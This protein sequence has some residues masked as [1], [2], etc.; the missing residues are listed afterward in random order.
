MFIMLLSALAFTP[1]SDPAK[2]PGAASKY[3]YKLTELDSDFDR[4]RLSSGDRL[5][6][7]CE[8]LNKVGG[9]GWELI[10]LGDFLQ[11]PL[12][13][14]SR[15]HLRHYLRR[16]SAAD[17]RPRWEYEV[18]DL[19]KVGLNPAFGYESPDAVDKALARVAKEESDGWLLVAALDETDAGWGS[20]VDQRYFLFK[21]SRR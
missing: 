9:E 7:L 12:N 2:E 13:G 6:K 17:G 8:S 11:R 20:R 19:G 15:L 4:M 16:P 14:R 21:R 18:V 1:S 5:R 10:A 3:E